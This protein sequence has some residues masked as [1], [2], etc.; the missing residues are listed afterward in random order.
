MVLAF[1]GEPEST[2]LG[3]TVTVT[4]NDDGGDEQSLATSFFI[5]QFPS[6]YV[7]SSEDTAL[8]VFSRLRGHNSGHSKFFGTFP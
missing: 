3:F 6:R 1:G 8:A 7:H 4:R 5:Y 2:A